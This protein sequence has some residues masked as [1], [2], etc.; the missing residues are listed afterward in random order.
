MVPD[1]QFVVVVFADNLNPI[2][3]KISG[4][5][6]D[7]KTVVDEL[8]FR[9]ANS[10]ILKVVLMINRRPHSGQRVVFLI[11]PMAIYN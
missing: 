7:I 5:E 6:A 8:I 4:V 11:T 2:G 10:R 1:A 9:H 3:D